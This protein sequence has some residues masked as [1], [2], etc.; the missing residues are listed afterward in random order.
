L[1]TVN[2]KKASFLMLKTEKE[3]IAREISPRRGGFKSHPARFN[4]QIG[5]ISIKF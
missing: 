3:G 5:A 4:S 2:G 1:V